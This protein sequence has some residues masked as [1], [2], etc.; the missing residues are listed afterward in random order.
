MEVEAGIVRLE[1]AETFVISRESTDHADVV[2]VAVGHDGTLGYG[3][4][5]PIERYG[6]S[7][8]SAKS[9]VEEHAEFLG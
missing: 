7:A 4:G 3:E 6:E 9:F 8:E 1:L 5:A 2:Q